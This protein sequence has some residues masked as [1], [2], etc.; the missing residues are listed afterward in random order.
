M[1]SYRAFQ[2]G[3]GLLVALFLLFLPMIVPEMKIHLATEI[4]IFA[5]FGISFNLLLGYTGLLPFGYAALFGVGAYAAALMFNH[6]PGT[7]LVITLLIAAFAGL[8]TALFIGS[9]CVRLSGTYFALLTLAFQMFLFTVALKWRAV[10]N[11]DDGMGVIRPE[12]YLPGFGNLSLMNINNLYYVTLLIVVP[13]IFAA[14]LFLK[15]PLG[16]AVICMR[17]NDERASFLGYN[18][19]LTKLTVFSFAG[20]LAGAAGGLFVL[21]QEFVATTAID[22]N[23]SFTIVLMVIIG[24]KDRFLGPVMG[25]TVFLLFQDWISDVTIYWWLFMGL[26]FIVVVLYLE[27]GLISLFNLD[28]IWLWVNRQEK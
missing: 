14:Y 3:W 10:T 4:L 18:V 17:E 13:G 12:I 9:F 28:R 19:F 20:F 5:L 22:V 21:F 2:I 23:M 1:M 7:P 15:T 8:L 11:G 24:G 16:N 6:L 26:F 27:G 25:A